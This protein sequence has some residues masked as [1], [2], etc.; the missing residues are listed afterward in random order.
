MPRAQ[1]DSAGQG[2]RSGQPQGRPPRLLQLVRGQLR[3]RHYS[4]RTEKAY[5]GWI[6]RFVRFH[7]MRHPAELGPDEVTT[8][9][10]GLATDRRVSASTQ[11]QAAAAVLFLYRHVLRK[12]IGV[13]SRLIRA[14][15]PARLPVVLTRNEVKALL[16]ELHGIYRLVASLLYGSGLRLLECLTLRV[17]DIDIERGEIRVR[18]GKGGRDRVTVLP[19]Y[20]ARPL[21]RHLA[22]VKRLHL[23]DLARGGGRVELPDAL[24]RKYKAASREWGW[25]WVFPAVRTRFDH[26]MRRRRRHHLHESAVQRAVK[27]AVRAAG[28]AKPATCHT[29]RHS[30]ATHLLESGQDIR[31]VQELL[32]HRDVRTTMVY[33]HVLNRGAYGVQS[34]L[35]IL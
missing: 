8:F 4:R 28:I 6:R 15:T 16:R 31:T 17:K 26:Q 32:G 29:L 2:D 24:F 13:T 5:V 1:D 19:R 11:N 35:D 30:F 27:A 22:R 18:R 14:A 25:Q 12:D 21:T 20:A 7:G 33:T 3:L 9:L 10:S 34:P 23:A